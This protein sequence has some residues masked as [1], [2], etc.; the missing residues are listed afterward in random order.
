MQWTRPSRRRNHEQ[1]LAGV[2]LCGVLRAGGLQPAAAQNV[3]RCGDS[4][5]QKPCP[6]GA[7]VPTD[8]A[9]SAAQ[10]AQTREAAQ[11]DGKTADAM[12]KA[13]LKE[14]AKPAQAYMTPPMGEPAAE[15]K[16]TDV[17]VKPKKPQYFTAAAARKPGEAAPKKKSKAKKKKDAEA[18][19][20]DA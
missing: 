10:K 13:R 2:Y 20:N 6:G 18:K 17:A 7:L 5:S 15:E 3:Y 1:E 8:D 9:R 14:E 16:K 4:Y 11:R 12:E 19:K